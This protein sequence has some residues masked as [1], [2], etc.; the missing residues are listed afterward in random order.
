MVKRQFVSVRVV[1][2]AFH[3]VD[4]GLFAAVGYTMDTMY[5]GSL[6]DPIDTNPNLQMPQFSLV[7]KI[8]IDCSQNYTT[9]EFILS[10]KSE[11][12]VYLELSDSSTVFQR[13]YNQHKHTLTKEWYNYT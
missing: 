7:D 2:A 9:G 3:I 8:L 5:F 1:F 11:N 13:N 6:D 4:V 12:S 10:D